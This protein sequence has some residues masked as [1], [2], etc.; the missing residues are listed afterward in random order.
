MLKTMLHLFPSLF[1]QTN[2]IERNQH[3]I[4]ANVSY[5][6]VLEIQNLF[7]AYAKKPKNCVTL[8]QIFINTWL[9]MSVLIKPMHA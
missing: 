1:A 5:V 7:V 2:K 8:H 9:R 4:M 3:I 6:M